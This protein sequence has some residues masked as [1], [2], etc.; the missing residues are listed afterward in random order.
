MCRPLRFAVAV[1]CAAVAALW[2]LSPAVATA[3][4]SK[5]EKQRDKRELQKD[6]ARLDAL[7]R[8]EKDLKTQVARLEKQLPAAR[9]QLDKLESEARSIDKQ[10]SATRREAEQARDAARD[11]KRLL[12][13]VVK[14]IE[15][16]QP[17]DSPFGKARAAYL[18][19][20][21]EQTAA[22]EAIENSPE[23][24][25]ARKTAGQSS[26]NVLPQMRTK[27]IDGNP[28]V[29]AARKQLAEAKEVYEK[30]LDELLRKDS[31]W[32]RTSRDEERARDRETDAEKRL[33]GLASL[34]AKSDRALGAARAAVKQMESALSKAKHELKGIP[35]KKEALRREIDRD[36]RDVRN[37]R[38]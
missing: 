12:A 22:I 2:I 33:N 11:A 23:Y 35:A 8:E 24:Q 6:Q 7:E 3:A 18:A 30:L 29:V 14:R 9:S 20:R 26:A 10:L 32:Q 4:E 5:K 38:K 19:A 25:A 21:A 34:N 27:W 36:R 17:S 16:S 31:T 15:E 37:P 28:A 13:A 1:L